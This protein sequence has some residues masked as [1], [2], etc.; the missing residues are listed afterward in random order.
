[1][2]GG[3]YFTQDFVNRYDFVQYLCFMIDRSFM[4]ESMVK[5]AKENLLFL[6]VV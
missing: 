3:P 5:R 4:Y 1:M 2:E 6:V